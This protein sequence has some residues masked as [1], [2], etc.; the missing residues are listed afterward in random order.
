[1][2][3]P[4]GAAAIEDVIDSASVPAANVIARVIGPITFVFGASAVF[5]ELHS[6]LNHIWR[7]AS[8]P[9]SIRRFVGI[10]LLSF[11]LVISA[12]FLSIVSLLLNTALAAFG[13]YV[14]GPEIVER[15]WLLQNLLMVVVLSAMFAGI[16]KVIPDTNVVWRDVWVGGL[17]TGVL[18]TGGKFL[19]SF[20]LAQAD[21]I[22]SYGAAGTLILVL[23][24]VYYSCQIFLFGAEITWQ[25]QAQ[26]QGSAAKLMQAEAPAP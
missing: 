4:A 10:R 7:V 11:A 25:W 15:I 18:F 3:G 6:V 2:I 1:V 24:W 21:V 12:G 23:L 20:Y 22:S 8:P 26:R 14:F 5:V 16:Y 9:F 19:V 17:V 13:A